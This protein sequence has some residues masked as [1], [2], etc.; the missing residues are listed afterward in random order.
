VSNLKQVNLAWVLYSADVDDTMMPP[1]THHSGSKFLYWWA[2]YDGSTT[3]QIEEEG[4][5]FP[6]TKGKGIQADPLFP[7]RLRAATGLTGYGY[8]YRF[9]GSGVTPMTQVSDPS[10]TVNFATSAQIDWGP[11]RQLQGNTYLESPS[12]N[13]P[14]FH[15]RA[16]GSGVVSWVDGHVNTRKPNYRT[17]NSHFLGEIDQDGNLFTDELFDL[18]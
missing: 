7:N 17:P 13:F 1:R 3:N 18:N 12:Q 10:Q 15:A 8:N 4:L 5:L 14:T 16:S 11:S 9:L 2:S 6:Y